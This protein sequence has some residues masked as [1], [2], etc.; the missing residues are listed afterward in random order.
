MSQSPACQH[1]LLSPIYLQHLDM[2]TDDR[3]ATHVATEIQNID[4][5]VRQ[6]LEGFRKIMKK[7]TKKTKLSKVW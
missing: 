4:T 7:Y 1:H 5:Y 3:L 6:N 2:H